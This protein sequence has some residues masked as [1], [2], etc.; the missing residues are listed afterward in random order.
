MSADQARANKLM[1]SGDSRQRPENQSTI[2]A[3]AAHW[4]TEA[5]A[6]RHKSQMENSQQNQPYNNSHFANT[7][8]EQVGAFLEIV[9]NRHGAIPPP[10]GSAVGGESESL[11]VK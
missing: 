5:S 1:R 7:A 11:K 9:T 8:L 2:G 6:S 4:N 10:C 3:L